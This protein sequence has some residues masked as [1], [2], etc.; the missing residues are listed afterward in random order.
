MRGTT[1]ADGHVSFDLSSVQPS[2]EIAGN[3]NVVVRHTGSSAVFA[4]DIRASS[5]YATSKA[6]VDAAR[7]Q[8]QAQ[9]QVES[10]RREA[11]Q[12]AENAKREAQ[13]QAEDAKREAHQK[14]LR[15]A[16]DKNNAQ[17][18]YQLGQE[19]NGSAGGELI[20]RSCELNYQAGCIL[21]QQILHDVAA[22]RA[23][24]EEAAAQAAGRRAQERADNAER[25]PKRRTIANYVAECVVAQGSLNAEG[26][27]KLSVHNEN[28]QRLIQARCKQLCEGESM[29]SC[30]MRCQ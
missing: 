9:A 3:P 19:I 10:E 13:Q 26:A 11:Q 20:K 23:R 24:A 16:C 17:A 30:D 7:A 6:G 22:A 25:D 15:D 18:C 4:V 27:C 29:G 21:Y 2:P 12:Q 28:T 1:G 5:L 8:A 14:P